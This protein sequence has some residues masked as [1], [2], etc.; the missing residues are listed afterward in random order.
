MTWLRSIF[1][2]VGSVGQWGAGLFS[3]RV[4]MLA[5]WQWMLIALVP[6]LIVLLY[7]LKLKRQPLEVPSTYLWHKS[8]EDLHVNSIWQR[9][10]QSLLLYLQLAFIAL[11][12]WT[13]LK[14]TLTGSRLLGHRFIFLVDTSA[15]MSATDVAPTR[16]DEAKKR[17]AELIAEMQTGDVA[18]LISFSDSAK[19]EKEFTEDTRELRRRLEAIKQTDRS[20]SVAEALRVASGLANPGRSSNREDA[21]DVQVADA[22]PATLYIF[23]DGKFPRVKNFSLGHLAEDKTPPVYV[24]IGDADAK[25]VAI[26]AFTIG[27]QEENPD[28]LQA[29][30]RI[31]NHGLA[32]ASVVAELTLDGE[33][34]DANPIEI[35]P[36]ES[37]GV[38]FDLTQVETG[39]LKLS[40]DAK[41]ALAIDDHAWATLNAR[42]RS[43][44]LLI[45]ADDKPV[46][47]AM[48]TERVRELADVTLRPPGFLS[49]PEYRKEAE[50]GA[51]DLMI[52]DGCRPEQMPQAN[53]LFIGR[54]PVGDTWKAGESVDVPQI[55][56]VDHAH[57]LMQIVEM[58]AV[59]IVEGTPLF[60][61]SGGTTLI[62]TNAGSMFAIAPREGYEDAVLGF[63]IVG[64]NGNVGTNWPI[65][66]SFPVFML[67]VVEYL[68]GARSSLDAGSVR[69]GQPVAW[70]Y[71]TASDRLRIK[72]PKGAPYEVS[73]GR[74]ST[75][76]VTGTSE[77]GV[78]EV[79]DQ[80][81]LAGRFSV[82]LFDS[83]ESDIRPVTEVPVGDI[84]V[85]GKTNREPARRDLWKIVLLAA[86]AVLLAE[87]YIYNRRVYV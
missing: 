1:E 13:L 15:S 79:Y 85:E 70:R 24:P 64:A 75:F 17:V 40:T 82:N 12:A 16:L 68:G 77:V 21:N 3:E 28:H 53:T 29:F 78:Y 50:G 83:N 84:K 80:D 54:L 44:V 23:S 30:G 55:I 47:F 46:E 22:V 4:Q 43:K 52:Y 9:L 6:I 51:Y 27:R 87:W 45:T 69:P 49:Q 41:D 36:G 71:D 2:R 63:S 26:A 81:K 35:E 18:M 42:R 32:K 62:D 66:A 58:G 11:L 37:A 38:A 86:L 57:P 33:L 73:R 31:E 8:I 60:P 7:F 74:L 56:D 34:I 61:P 76:N 67:N 72:P 25:N 14:P 39:V 20:T 48:N 59:L 5:V 65:V 19:V 10:R